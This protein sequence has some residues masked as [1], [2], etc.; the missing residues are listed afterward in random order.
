MWEFLLEMRYIK[1]LKIAAFSQEIFTIP[2]AP[3]EILK[4]NNT[5]LKKER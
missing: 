5:L 2:A 4:E 1:M 3:N